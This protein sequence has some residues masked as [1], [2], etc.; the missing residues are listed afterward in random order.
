M[1]EDAF[2]FPCGNQRLFGILHKPFMQNGKAMVFCHPFAEEKLWSHRVFVNFARKLAVEGFH[3]LRFDFMG[4][5]DSSGNF[6]DTDV[7]TRIENI[8]C[9][10]KTLF[11]RYPGIEELY[12]LGLRFGATLTALVAEQVEC[13]GI[14][15]WEPVIKGAAHIK[16]L[17]RI[18]LTTQTAVY[19]EIRYNTNEL[20]KK[21]ENGDSIN[22][23]GY[24]IRLPLYKQ[25]N[26]IDLSNRKFT[27]LGDVLAVQINKRENMG[28]KRI[29]VLKNSYKNCRLIETIEQP[30][31][32]EIREYYSQAKNLYE[33]TLNWLNEK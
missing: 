19:K 33:T 28:I 9:A 29:E 27:F 26:D 25:I 13:S 8:I 12:L 14:I 23:D 1:I 20:I 10:V 32:K 11:Q 15:L 31:W 2:F 21:L 7:N 3:I 22:L 17:I 16:E 18:N 5:G 6:E 24:E 30:F 4:H